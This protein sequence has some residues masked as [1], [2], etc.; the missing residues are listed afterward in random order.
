MSYYL[1]VFSLTCL[2]AWAALPASPAR[3]QDEITI[4]VLQFQRSG[5]VPDSVLTAVEQMVYSKFTDRKR[6]RVIE[7]SQLDAIHAELAAQEIMGVEQKTALASIGANY[8]A[9]GQ[10]TQTDIGRSS[11]SQGSTFYSAV[12]SYGIRIIDVSTGSV[13]YS[14]SFSNGR[15]NPFANAFSGFTGDNTTPAGAIDIAVQQTAKQVDS[16]LN[17]SFPTQGR[18]VS[19]ESRNRKGSAESVLVTLG[20]AEG[21]GKRSKA[22]AFR[23]ETLL[24]DGKSLVRKKPIAELTFVRSEGEQLSVFK[25]SKASGSIDDAVGSESVYVELLP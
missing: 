18:L 19:I 15:G 14:E 25:I 22:I 7:R 13:A 20:S 17:T 10:V 23:Q 16:F 8:V 6:F 5:N 11:G 3:A 2:L 12:I 21:V 24:I 4:G 9:I 1:R